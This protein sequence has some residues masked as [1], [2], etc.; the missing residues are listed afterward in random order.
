[1][2]LVDSRARLATLVDSRPLSVTL[3]DPRALSATLVDSRARLVTLVDSRALSAIFVDSRG[4][5]VT[6]GRSQ[7]RSYTLLVFLLTFVWESCVFSATLVWCRWLSSLLA[8]FRHLPSALVSTRW[9]RTGSD[10]LERCPKEQL[11]LVKVHWHANKQKI[12]H[13]Q[14]LSVLASEL[15]RE[16]ILLLFIMFQSCGRDG[17]ASERDGTV[18]YVILPM[19]CF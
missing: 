10:F 9:I 14:L 18:A 1:M 5:S 16:W 6:L 8:D 19:P 2:T 11:I 17:K 4:L 3:V 7:W 15:N 13:P 12:C